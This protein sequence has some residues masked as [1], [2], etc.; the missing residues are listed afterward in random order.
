M[1]KVLSI[2][3]VCIMVFSLAACGG[4]DNGSNSN[5]GSSAGNAVPADSPFIGEWIGVGGEAWGLPMTAKDAAA[6]TL[7]VKADGKAA[8]TTEGSPLEVAW[9]T[10]GDKITLKQE[11]I[12]VSSTGTLKDGAILFDDLM[13]LGI[14]IY[15][16]KEGT[17][18]ADPA[19]YIPETDKAMVGTWTSYAVTDILE[20]D[21]SDVVPADS[22][23]ITF[24]SDYTA[25]VKIGELDIPDQ[26]W[27]LSDGF[28]YLADSEY[29]IT[30]DVVD[31]EIKICYFDDQSDSY[32]F[33]CKKTE[34][35]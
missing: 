16:A 6:Y 24:R 22:F 9:N 34:N 27:A 25:D 31:D 5:G 13:D 19:L 8:L 18:A 29:D 30:W 3:L 14:K 12:D 2:V 35:E 15:F 10:D 23:T 11:N 33:M 21:I 17:D 4:D 1:K 20:D 7:S 28:G 32:Y 26:T